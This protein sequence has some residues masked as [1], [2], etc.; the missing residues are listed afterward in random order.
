[1]KFENKL[2][3]NITEIIASTIFENSG[4]R[5]VPLG[6]EKIVREVSALNAERYKLL[7]LSQTLRRT[8]DLLVT[9][10]DMSKAWLVEI[11][12]RKSFDLFLCDDLKD[13][14][15]DQL[16]YWEDFWVLLFVGEKVPTNGGFAGSYCGLVKLCMDGGELKFYKTNGKDK[17]PWRLLN[18]GSFSR[19]QKIFDKVEKA[20]SGSPVEKAIRIIKSLP[21][22]DES[23]VTDN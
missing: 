6:V 2:K 16:R 15:I 20:K 19:I 7:S 21:S 12:Y 10:N 18:W 9:E 4:Y 3:G 11:K 1:M 23:L 8:P 22:L 5:V 13:I 17:L 14:F